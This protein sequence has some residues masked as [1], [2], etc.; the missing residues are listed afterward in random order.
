VLAKH[1]GQPIPQAGDSALCWE[2]AALAPILS[3]G[4]PITHE[5][6]IRQG[7][8]FVRAVNF[9]GSAL[10]LASCGD[11]PTENTPAEVDEWLAEATR[12]VTRILAAA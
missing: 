1:Q 9:Q 6:D 4:T 3:R 2:L 7:L 5:I 11:S 12:G 8:L 10:Y